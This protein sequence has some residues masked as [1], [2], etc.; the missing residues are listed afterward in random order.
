MKPIH[1]ISIVE[2]EYRKYFDNFNLVWKSITLLSTYVFY[3][4]EWYI[5]NVFDEIDR[6]ISINEIESI[7][8]LA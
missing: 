3:D 7:N 8:E 4:M 2:L 6:F 1:S 5:I